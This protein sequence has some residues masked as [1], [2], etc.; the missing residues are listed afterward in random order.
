MKTKLLIAAL[1]LVLGLGLG[2]LL[3]WFVWP[4]EYYDTD[5]TALHPDYQVDYAVM[6][7]A[8][9]EQDNN[10]PRAEARL[11]ALGEPDLVTWLQTTIHRAIAKG[12]DPVEIR[13]LVSLTDP[14]DARTEIMEPFAGDSP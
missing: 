3:G 1:G 4:V 10:W 8:A 7:G 2:F 14:L 13:H 6:V 5:L 9:Y 12:R 11:L